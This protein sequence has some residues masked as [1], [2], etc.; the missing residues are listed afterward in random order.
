[1]LSHYILSDKD[2]RI[3]AIEEGSRDYC[4]S[5]IIHLLFKIG[6]GHGYMSKQRLGLGKE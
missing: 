2:C 3:A 5:M 6:V 4:Y 1:M